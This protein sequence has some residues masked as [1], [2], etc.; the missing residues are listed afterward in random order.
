[1]MYVNTTTFSNNSASS[2]G[3]AWLSTSPLGFTR[4]HNTIIANNAAAIGTPD[5][6]TVFPVKWLMQYG[7]KFDTSAANESVDVTY[8]Q[9]CGG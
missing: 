8:D 3:A 5:F 2:G 1:M 6:T 4:I 9:L 7:D